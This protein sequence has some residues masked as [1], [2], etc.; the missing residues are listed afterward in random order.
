MRKF[1]RLVTWYGSGFDMPFLRARSMYHNIDF[2]EREE[3][4]H[5]DAYMMGRGKIKIHSKRLQVVAEFLD[6]A[7][8]GHPL[9]YTVWLQ[10]HTGDKKALNYILTHCQE[11]VVTTELVWKR[12]LPY[13]RVTNTSI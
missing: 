11:D 12:L 6:I 5:N 9:N 2:P 13:L 7:A 4:K 8:K 3:V 1:D 10:A